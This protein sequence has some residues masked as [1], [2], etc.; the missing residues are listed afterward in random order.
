MVG[1]TGSLLVFSPEL[2]TYQVKNSLPKIISQGERRSIEDL[3]DLTEDYLRNSDK[4]RST[5]VE[6]SGNTDSF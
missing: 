3:C 2:A 1:L 6:Q 4:T 5:T